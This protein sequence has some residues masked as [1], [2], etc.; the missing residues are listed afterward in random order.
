MG[1][2]VEENS[3]TSNFMRKWMESLWFCAVSFNPPNPMRY[4]FVL[5]YDFF[6]V[7]ISCVVFA[8]FSNLFCI[9]NSVHD[10]VQQINWRDFSLTNAICSPQFSPCRMYKM[11]DHI[12]FNRWRS[13]LTRFNWFILLSDFCFFF[14]FCLPPHTRFFLLS[15]S[16]SLSRPTFQFRYLHSFRADWLVHWPHYDWAKHDRSNKRLTK[17]VADAFAG[18]RATSIT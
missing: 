2:R 8:R 15:L 12:K 6:F 4:V 5:P 3:K 14:F 16:L 1:E 9:V 18:N 10:R 17:I 11:C 13:S 7:N